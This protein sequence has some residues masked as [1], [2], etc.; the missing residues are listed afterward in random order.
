VKNRIHFLKSVFFI[1]VFLLVNSGC[2]SEGTGPTRNKVF[3]IDRIFRDYYRQLGASEVLGPVISEVFA[4]EDNQCQYVENAL[5]CFNPGVIQNNGYFLFPLGALFGMEDSFLINN[6]SPEPIYEEFLTLYEAIGGEQTTGKMLTSVRYNLQEKRIEQYFE[7]VGFY[8]RINGSK[9]QVELLA[10]G[11]FG[12]NAKCQFLSKEGAAVNIHAN[13]VEMPFLSFISRYDHLEAFGEPL[14]APIEI[15]PGL[16][17]QVYQN[18]VFIGNPELPETIH[19]LDLPVRLGLQQDEPKPQFY[20]LDD[21]MVFYV[22]NGLNGFHVPTVFDEFI[23]QHGGRELSGNPLSEVFEMEDRIRQCFQNF[24]L[25][26]EPSEKRVELVPLGQQYLETMNN[27]SDEVVVFDYTP[28][29]VSI[30]IQEK[31]P[32]ISLNEEQELQIQ[33]LRTDNKA[34]IQNITANL[35]ITLPN[36]SE[37]NYPFSPTDEFGTSQVTIPPVKRVQ[38]GSVLTYRVC[39]DLPSG[40]QLCKKDSYLIW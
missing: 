32:S 10:Y 20:N 1:L 27:V 21:N 23:I 34:P 8:R 4:W 7:N 17:Q 5:L 2:A 3:G 33:V 31:S 9:I 12:C 14:T 24:C 37:L 40:E 18:V 19:L 22:V 38:N 25:D 13:V 15:Q 26:Y 28:E 6:S 11:T 29:T 39:V 16:I 36:G 30:L 35:M